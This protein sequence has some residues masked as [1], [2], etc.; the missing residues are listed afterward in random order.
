MIA[1]VS[2]YQTEAIDPRAE[3]WLGQH[4][5]NETLRRSGLWNINRVDEAYDP[6]FLARFAEA[7]GET[8]PV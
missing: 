6:G 5:P 4:S 1:L 3:T 7:I 8:G 2:N